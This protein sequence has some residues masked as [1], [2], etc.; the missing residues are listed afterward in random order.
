MARWPATD[1]PLA[2]LF[3]A[4]VGEAGDGHI[5][6]GVCSVKGEER[7]WIVCPRRLLSFHAGR[8][9]PQQRPLLDRVL[10]L[11]G[12]ES[13]EK[14]DVWAE[15]PLREGNFNY[16]LDYVLRAGA[17]APIIVEIMTASTSGGN[18]AKRTDIKSAFCDAVLYACGLS[19]ERGASPGA[20]IRQVWARM[21]SQLIVKSEVANR[22]GGRA[23]W[24]VQDK[25]VDYIRK[26]TGLRVDALD[27]TDTW[28]TDE[29]NVVS[30]SMDDPEDIR[31]YA[32][33]VQSSDGGPS[34]SELLRT[35]SMPDVSSLTSG[36]S[37]RPVVATITA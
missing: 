9:S 1:Q 11:A 19:P 7:A 25:L 16:R 32:G 17:K 35:P 28:R 31:L 15:V 26:H 37:N 3:D 18:R 33:P 22:W 2:P 13:G 21:A 30:A 23:I 36:L 20:N 34:W 6:C 14:V 4:S 27:A 29:V 5:P 24:V 12:F 10:R 8:P